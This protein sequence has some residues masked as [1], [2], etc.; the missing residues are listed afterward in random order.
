MLEFLKTPRF[1]RFFLGYYCTQILSLLLPIYGWRRNSS[2][3]KGIPRAE[4]KQTFH[5]ESSS[6]G[7]H[8]HNP[9]M[10]GLPQTLCTSASDSAGAPQTSLGRPHTRHTSLTHVRHTFIFKH[11]AS[12]DPSFKHQSR[13]TPHTPRE[14]IEM[15]VLPPAGSRHQLTSP[16]SS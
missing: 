1:S 8:K 3:T 10:R 6:G 2:S 13:H 11:R 5:N 14:R 12:S 9:N 7:S 4:N 16:C 15:R